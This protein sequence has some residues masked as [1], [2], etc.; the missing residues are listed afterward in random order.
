MEWPRPSFAPSNAITSQAFGSRKPVRRHGYLRWWQR[1]Q[2]EAIIA[3]IIG[4]T[5]N[6]KV[7]NGWALWGR[8]QI[9]DG[10]ELGRGGQG[11]GFRVNRLLGKKFVDL[12]WEQVDF[13]TASLHVRRVKR[14]SQKA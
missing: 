8:W 13:K 12:Q 6:A 4:L 9:I 5:G 10:S 2:G 11:M 1:G 3:A 7:I 14:A